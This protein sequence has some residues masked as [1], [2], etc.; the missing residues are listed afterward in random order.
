MQSFVDFGTKTV[1]EDYFFDHHLDTF[2]NVSF[3]VPSLKRRLILLFVP[4]FLLC[5]L[6]VSILRCDY[7]KS[8]LCP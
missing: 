7:I 4:V 1:L 8:F 6:L 5:H 2:F 3:F